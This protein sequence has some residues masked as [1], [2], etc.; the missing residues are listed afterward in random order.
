MALASGSPKSMT[1]LR[2]E[3]DLSVGALSTHVHL[4][5]AAGLVA[6]D[7]MGREGCVGLRPGWEPLVAGLIN[8][9]EALAGEAHYDDDLYEVPK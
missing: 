8:G 6:I 9:L 3:T 7:R 4:L 5:A 2:E 1:Q